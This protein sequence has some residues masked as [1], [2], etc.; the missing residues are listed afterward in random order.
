MATTGFQN[1]NTA[2]PTTAAPNV[3]NSG[4][5]ATWYEALAKAWGQALDTQAGQVESL[6]QQLNDGN[7]QPS[8]IAMLTAESQKMMFL[9]NSS[10]SSVN[11]VGQSLE[12]MARKS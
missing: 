3:T 5:S 12:T 6:A 4:K 1:V 7:D 9:A 11:A 2:L 8:T 10:S